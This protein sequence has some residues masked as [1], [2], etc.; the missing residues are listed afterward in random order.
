MRDRHLS[1]NKVISSVGVYHT[2]SHL[3][4]RK[5]GVVQLSQS[6][7]P[8]LQMVVVSAY[9]RNESRGCMIML[10]RSTALRSTYASLCM[11]VNMFIHTCTMVFEVR[12]N[13]VLARLSP[14]L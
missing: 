14:V 3:L 2:Q 11:Y 13:K 9:R 1:F 5:V 4:P 12:D 8:V 7:L 10:K 6:P